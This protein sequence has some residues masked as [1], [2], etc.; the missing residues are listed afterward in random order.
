[1][2]FMKKADGDRKMFVAAVIGA[3]AAGMMAAGCM[4]QSGSRVA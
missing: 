1:M 4:A 3:G 2:V